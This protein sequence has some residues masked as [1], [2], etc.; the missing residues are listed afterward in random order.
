MTSALLDVQ[1]MRPPHNDVLLVLGTIG[2]ASGAFGGFLDQAPNRLVSG[3][4]LSLAQIADPPVL[5]GLGGIVGVLIVVSLLPQRRGLYRA[6]LIG[7]IALLLLLFHDAGWNAARLAAMGPPVARISLGWAFWVTSAC[8]GLAA[9][10][11]AQ[12][13]QLKP[14]SQ[15]ALVVAVVG[16]IA[17]MAAAGIFDS[18][19]VAR[20]YAAR[21]AV[22]ADELLRHAMLVGGALTPGLA[23]G[24][25]L[26]LLAAR[27]PRIRAPLFG[28]L[29]I[30]QT[31]P[32]VA[33]F[34]LLIAPLSTLATD[35][36]GLA[37]LGIRGVGVAPAIIALV[38]YSLLPVVRN[39]QAGIETADPSVVE[40]ARAMG[41]TPR[42][43]FWRIEV[44]LGM[45][46]FLAGLRIVLVQAIGLAAIAA[47]IGGGG[48]GTFIFQGIGEYATDLVLLGAIP[49]MLMALAADFLLRLAIASIERRRAA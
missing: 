16:A 25:P 41:F 24:V 2:V 15:L 8:A 32:S 43:I 4:P 48:L 45:P 34:G 36:P 49:I 47:L 40:A 38:L 18:L 27:R 42:Q 35:F 23:I 6:V 13:L 29:N 22:F 28:T 30:L 21:R 39:I 3:H 17:G 5:I 7:A 44:P 31:I 9:I 1:I 11:G 20:E 19:S 10:D 12:R 33:L 46:V 37:A 26:G 14:L